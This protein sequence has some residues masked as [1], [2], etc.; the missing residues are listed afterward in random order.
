MKTAHRVASTLLAAL[1]FLSLFTLP[2]QA[3]SYTGTVNKD[4]VF[5]RSKPNTSSVYYA[6][7]KKGTKVSITGISGNF[8]KVEYDKQSGYIMKSLVNAPSA[9][10]KEFGEKDKPKAASK[11]ENIRRISDLGKLP[12]ATRR[13]SYG[14]DVEKLQRALQIKG[15]LKGGLDGKYGNG[16]ADAVRRFQKSVKLKETGRADKETINLLFGKAKAASAKDDPGMKGITSISKIEVPNT[17]NPGNY[18]RHV[19]ALQQALKLRGYYKEDINSRYDK[20]TVEAVKRF[21]KSRG[22]TS[23]GIAGNN[24]IKKL[25]GKNAANYTIPTNKVDWFKGGKNVIP[26]WSSFVVKDVATGLTF[27]VRRWSGYNHMDVEPL[28][29]SDAATLKKIAGGSYSWARRAILIKYNGKV[30]AASMNTM[31]HG[32]QSIRNNEYPGHFCIHFPNSKT[33]GTNRVDSSHQS[34]V[35]RASGSDW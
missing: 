31:P 35:R 34:A 15:F 18:G 7:L 2:A 22:L 17:S 29:K 8:Y 20:E 19:K 24:T 28:T 21:Q 27:S 3:A 26:Q 11:Y 32:E 33:H 5:F 13:G 4:K 16:T 9:A 6:V 10:K 1:L 12:R 23:D 14:D 30:Y 25:F